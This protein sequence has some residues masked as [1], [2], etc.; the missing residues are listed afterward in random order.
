MEGGASSAPSLIVFDAT[1]VVGAALHRDSVPR[2]AIELARSHHLIAFSDPVALEI[3]EVLARP[4]FA[5]Q[6]T[7]PRQREI[8]DLLFVDAVW[9]APTILAFDCRDQDDNKYLELALA[10]QATTVV[11]SDSDL[12]VLNPL[13]GVQI[14]RPVAFLQV[15]AG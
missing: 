4:K 14:L 6:L 8:I 15:Q 3:R 7:P 5:R 2:R 9:F 1:T 12:L 11:S 13:R 10:A